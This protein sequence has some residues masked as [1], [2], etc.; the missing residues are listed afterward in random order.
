MI[1]GEHRKKSGLVGIKRF[2][3]FALA[4]CVAII[5]TS[6][7]WLV[8]FARSTLCF[9]TR[10]WKEGVIVCSTLAIGIGGYLFTGLLKPH[11]SSWS[12][13][14]TELGILDKSSIAISL[15]KVHLDF[16]DDKEV[17]VCISGESK[18][19]RG[20]KSIALLL[21]IPE[22][23]TIRDVTVE[24]S[25]HRQL[26][27][28]LSKYEGSTTT[29][30][31]EDG[32]MSYPVEKGYWIVIDLPDNVTKNNILLWTLR[33]TVYL[34]IYRYWEREGGE[35]EST[36]R[37]FLFSNALRQTTIFQIKTTLETLAPFCMLELARREEADGYTW[38]GVLGNTETQR[39]PDHLVFYLISQMGPCY[40]L[41]IYTTYFAIPL[42]FGLAFFVALIKRLPRTMLVCF[43]VFSAY[44]VFYFL[45]QVF[46][47]NLRFVESRV[48]PAVFPP[49]KSLTHVGYRAIPVF[50]LLV[51]ACITTISCLAI[52]LEETVIAQLSG[53]RPRVKTAVKWVQIGEWILFGAYL[54][55]A[56]TFTRINITSALMV[57]CLCMAFI[58]MIGAIWRL[59][60]AFGLSWKNMLVMIVIWNLG[61]RLASHLWPSIFS[62]G[63]AFIVVW[64]SLLFLFAVVRFR[65]LVSVL[66]IVRGD[67]PLRILRWKWRRWE[68]KHKSTV[69]LVFFIAAL[70]GILAA[71]IAIFS[72]FMRPSY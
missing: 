71:C 66:K 5:L 22:E 46:P 40:Y 28:T 42:L 49:L 59:K 45:N 12:A 37:F 18:V 43:V 55:T 6:F 53:R 33:Y 25:N 14:T 47:F 17:K 60:Q 70:V 26:L 2:L 20:A 67:R 62:L 38:T 51:T 56:I 72:V 32:L 39:V 10:N 9:C 44:V 1:G 57:T 34:P 58:T 61:F 31:T 29:Y 50:L 27:T 41:A 30:G 48:A 63:Q 64:A 52:P 15:A 4:L 69:R 36:L 16:K 11:E 68:E 19:H 7:R 65:F 23:A 54:N 13:E 3:L 8:G 24:R 21:T 35:L